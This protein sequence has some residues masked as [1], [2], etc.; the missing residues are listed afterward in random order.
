MRALWLSARAMPRSSSSPFRSSW[1]AFLFL[2]FVEHLSFGLSC[3]SLYQVKLDRCSSPRRCLTTDRKFKADSLISSLVPT[4]VH[5]HP[6]LSPPGCSGVLLEK[7]SFHEHQ[8]GAHGRQQGEFRPFQP[9][10]LAGRI[11]FTNVQSTSPVEHASQR[12]ANLQ[13]HVTF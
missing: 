5:H 9:A 12:G 10:S 7:L 3:P 2:N 4:T 13:F 11:P 8:H 6:T 1:E